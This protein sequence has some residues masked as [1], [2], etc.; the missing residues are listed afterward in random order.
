[1]N[2]DQIKRS[3]EDAY[4]PDNFRQMGHRLIDQ[5]ADY[6]EGALHGRDARGRP[7]PVLPAER[8]EE[9]V[10]KY[11]SI[12]SDPAIDFDSLMS[13][14]I[15]D[16]IHL[17]HPGYIGHQVSA[18]VPLASLVEMAGTFLN[19]GSAI[20]DMGPA[21]L[22]ME[23]VVVEKM[24]AML[25]FDKKADG[26]FTSGGSM[27]NLTALL[28]ARE[29]ALDMNKD[30]LLQN[31]SVLVSAEAHYSISRSLRILGI[32][33]IN[34]IAVPVNEQGRMNLELVPSMINDL[35][36]KGKKACI[37]CANACSTATGIYDPL[38]EAGSL[39]REFGLWFHVDGAHGVSAA[40]SN[41][42]RILITGINQAH[43]VVIDFHKMMLAPGLLTLVLFADERDSWR[44]NTQRQITYGTEPVNWSGIICRNGQLNVPRR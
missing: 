7:M 2:Y 34:I 41:R 6:L 32:P 14:I 36:S 39:C 3:L 25:E 37:L 18:P 26:L 11:S 5:L 23:R 10:K 35:H 9:L 1:M 12:W 20:Y 24:A 38:A 40:F 42:Y 8:P 4:S 15:L 27:G 31:L 16:A 29:W 17:H 43:S 33:D 44:T 28:A 13:N 21:S 22:A 19:N 30:L